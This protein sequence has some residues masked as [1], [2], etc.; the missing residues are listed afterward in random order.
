MYWSLMNDLTLTPEEKNDLRLGEEI[1]STGLYCT[2][3]RQCLPQCPHGVDIPRLMRS[4]M[5]AYGYRKPSKAKE[6]LQ[7]VDTGKTKC[8]ECSS[9]DI[10]CSMGFNIR[11]KI[12]DIAR[13]KDIPDEFLA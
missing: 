2:Q 4:Y 3:C 9:C 7:L 1:S 11:K 10:E 6:T 8:N 13:I 5:Y 12:K